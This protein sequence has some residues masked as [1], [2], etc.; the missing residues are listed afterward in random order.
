MD[1]FH[2]ILTLPGSA[3]LGVNNHNNGGA[4][5]LSRKTDLET[6]LLNPLRYLLRPSL[7]SLGSWYRNGSPTSIVTQASAPNEDYKVQVL[8][9]KL[10]QVS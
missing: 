3:G 7:Q 1:E 9:L 4:R 2:D 5:H 10:G 6:G 8:R